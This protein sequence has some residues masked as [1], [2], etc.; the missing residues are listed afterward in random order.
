MN[1][2]ARHTSPPC[3]PPPYGI[4]R[5]RRKERQQIRL[6]VSIRPAGITALDKARVQAGDEQ[7]ACVCQDGG[8]IDNAGPR[9]CRKSRLIMHTLVISRR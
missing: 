7:D 4:H 5:E 6:A 3:A 9:G 8:E 2:R 1:M